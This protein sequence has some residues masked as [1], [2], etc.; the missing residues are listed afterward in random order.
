MA[1]EGASEGADP[2]TRSEGVRGGG[3]G[4]GNAEGGER[5]WRWLESTEAL[6][7]EAFRSPVDAIRADD[8][9]V[10]QSLKENVLAAVIELGE[11]TREFSWKPWAHDGPF[12]NRERVIEELVD[13]AHF[14][15]NMLVNLDAGDD[16]WERE[17]QQKQRTNR[18]RQ[19]VGYSARKGDR[20]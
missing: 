14:I 17:Y 12:V 5:R 1:Q 11:V 13:V 15:G 7:R 18:R 9:L 16:E 8:A 20:G 3:G 19:I 4:E 10:A 2:G 6:Q